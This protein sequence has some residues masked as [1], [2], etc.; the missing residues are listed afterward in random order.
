MVQQAPGQ[1]W[2]VSN[3]ESLCLWVH[4]GHVPLQLRQGGAQFAVWAVEQDGDERVGGAAVGH[5]LLG[6]EDGVDGVLVLDEERVLLDELPPCPPVFDPFKQEDEAEGGGGRAVQ[7]GHQGNATKVVN[8]L[9]LNSVGQ[10]I[11]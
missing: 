2:A 6:E 10:T 9:H 5:D 4:A 1:L 3:G 7:R 11:L 8:L